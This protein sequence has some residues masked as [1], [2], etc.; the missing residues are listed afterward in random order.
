MR[1]LL[2]GIIAIPFIVVVATIGTF[3]IFGLSGNREQTESPSAAEITVARD[4]AGGRLMVAVEDGQARAFEITSRFESDDGRNDATFVQP[5][6]SMTMIGHDMGRTP[7]QMFRQ[8]DG[9]WRGTGTFPMGGR[10]R[11]QIIFDG[12]VVELEHAAR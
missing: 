12:D 8:S 4:I 11:F 3:L 6:V 10:W 9:T 1:V 2:A 5:T 7:V